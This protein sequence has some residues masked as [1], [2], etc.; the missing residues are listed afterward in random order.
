M[1]S[2]EPT[3]RRH[4]VAITA[5]GICSAPPDHVITL[6]EVPTIKEVISSSASQDI[7]PAEST[8]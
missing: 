5:G 4:A 1:S 7:I 6:H 2:T 3:V 8:M